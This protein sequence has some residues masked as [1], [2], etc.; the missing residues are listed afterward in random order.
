MLRIILIALFFLSLATA[1]SAG[2]LIPVTSEGPREALSVVCLLEKC[3]YVADDEF[4]SQIRLLSP[5]NLPPK[6]EWMEDVVHKLY[7]LPNDKYINDQ[8]YL[9]NS[10]INWASGWELIRNSTNSIAAEELPV[11]AVI[12]SGIWAHIDMEQARLYN[13]TYYGI[14]DDNNVK[15]ITQGFGEDSDGHGTHVSGI[16]AATTN[17]STGIASVSGGRVRLLSIKASQVKNG[18]VILN[19]STI[20]A[21]LNFI[22][23]EIDKGV[24]IVAVNMS[25]GSYSS[26]PPE[27]YPLYYGINELKNRGVAVFAAAGNDGLNLSSNL[28]GNYPADLPLENVIS[29]AWLDPNLRLATKSNF[30]S[31]TSIAAPGERILSLYT[32]SNDPK[33]LPYA[34][35]SGTSMAS[36]FV[37]GTV[38]AA[39]YINPALKPATLVCML[40]E[41]AD[42]AGNL[43]GR[44]YDERRI[45]VGAFLNAVSTGDKKGCTDEFPQKPKVDPSYIIDDVILVDP[46]AGSGSGCAMSGQ[47][48][49]WTEL[50]LLTM[51]IIIFKIRRKNI[52]HDKTFTK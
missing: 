35:A 19:S 43:L 51:S 25:F 44:V 29:V 42:K 2:W 3:F 41:T 36:P 11:V 12:D 5:G 16:I 22:L 38:A 26:S 47:G 15:P 4:D 40:Y 30:G 20:I 45:N 37:A 14:D 23:E 49:A 48:N 39:S 1:S 7:A 31:R 32:E 17:N 9:R 10:T 46:P 50:I 28:S 18:E 33:E 21:A 24:N 34:Y 52:I 13:G 27:Q 6:T 8:W